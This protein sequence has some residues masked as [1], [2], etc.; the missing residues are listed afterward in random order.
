MHRE[1]SPSNSEDSF[2]I[3]SPSF[4][5]NSAHS[6]S[7]IQYSRA[8]IYYCSEIVD[9]LFFQVFKA[10]YFEEFIYSGL[11]G[12]KQ[13]QQLELILIVSLL[14]LVQNK[15][16]ALLLTR[17]LMRSIEGL[18][19]SVTRSSIWVKTMD[20]LQADDLSS[21]LYEHIFWFLKSDPNFSS[22]IPAAFDDDNAFIDLEYGLDRLDDEP[23]VH[24]RK[25]T[26]T[27]EKKQNIEMTDFRT[28]R[29]AEE[30]YKDDFELV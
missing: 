19:Y 9:A 15:N 2:I 5:S 3:K 25:P 14:K 26:I 6:D 13:R 20:T 8:F 11:M 27:V 22:S 18:I 24:N 10:R 17:K 12:E 7:R 4:L 28:R 29:N 1:F 30:E 21:L 23:I 16:K